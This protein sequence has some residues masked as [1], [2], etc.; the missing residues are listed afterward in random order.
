MSTRA[1]N[2]CMGFTVRPSLKPQA[3]IPGTVPAIDIERLKR[4]LSGPTYMIPNG[5]TPE[6]IREFILR[7]AA[8]KK[9]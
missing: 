8:S 5:L 2:D 7:A 3:R 4:A 1:N 9:E 6:E